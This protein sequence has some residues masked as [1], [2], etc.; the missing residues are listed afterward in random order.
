M[1][2][3]Q[4]HHQAEEG[5]DC[6]R[7]VTDPFEGPARSRNRGSELTETEDAFLRMMIGRLFRIV[8]YSRLQGFHLDTKPPV[9]VEA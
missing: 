8:G 1:V 6:L 3:I 5:F 9:V 2:A 4:W 7:A